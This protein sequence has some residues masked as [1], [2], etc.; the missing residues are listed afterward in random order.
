MAGSFG[1]GEGDV[2]TASHY[3]LQSL[4]LPSLLGKTLPLLRLSYLREAWGVDILR[5]TLRI[6]LAYAKHIR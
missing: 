5:A 2:R 6:Y 3:G 4:F 1:T